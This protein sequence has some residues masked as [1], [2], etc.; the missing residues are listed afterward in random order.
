MKNVPNSFRWWTFANDNSHAHGEKEVVDVT[1]ERDS[2]DSQWIITVCFDRNYS[3][4][5]RRSFQL[6]VEIVL[7]DE[8]SQARCF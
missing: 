2:E 5:M 8:S 3:F 1:N 4:F 7:P 6:M